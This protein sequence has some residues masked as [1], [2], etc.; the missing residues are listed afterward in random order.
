MANGYILNQVPAGYGAAMSLI[1]EMLVSAGWTYKASGDGLSGYSSTGKIFTGTGTGA[2]GWNNNRAWARLQDP[3]A[4]RELVMQHSAAGGLRI[5]Y[6]FSAKFTGGSPAATV[7]PSATDERVF[8]GAGTDASPTLSAFFPAG[9]ATT[10]V[11]FHGRANDA[12]PYGFW[13][14]CNTTPAGAIGAGFMMD[15]VTSVPEDIDP[16]VFHIGATGAYNSA[17]WG[18]SAAVHSVSAYLTPG[19]TNQGCYGHR[20]AAATAFEMWF[21]CGYTLGTTNAHGSAGVNGDAYVFGRL[22]VAQNTFNAK[23]D[24]LP[25]LYARAPV[26]SLANPGVKGWS[27]FARWVGLARN[28]AVDTLDNK[29]WVAIGHIWL[30]WD[31]TTIP[32]N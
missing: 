25:V 3:A 12:S 23:Y 24:V 2:L 5:K 29:S 17:G 20:D 16:V 21:P 6:S 31:G 30:P 13:W 8:W 15:P 1:A 10:T 22:G 7:T 11:K 4:G 28:H 18:H 9:V 32:T 27:S 26:A 14:C 19:T